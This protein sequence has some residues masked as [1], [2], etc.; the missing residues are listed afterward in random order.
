MLEERVAEL[1]DRLSAVEGEIKNTNSLLAEILDALRGGGLTPPAK[2]D[3]A[4]VETAPA[5]VEAIAKEA[6]NSNE[7]EPVAE[8]E[9]TSVQ[10][11]AEEAAAASYDLDDVR[12]AFLEARESVGKETAIG[13]IT[14]I[15]GAIKNISH[16]PKDKFAAVIAALKAQVTQEAA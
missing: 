8:A 1:A 6:D 7:P 5:K 4:E 3:E 13:A 11:F 2:P 12:A 9:P 15:T 14:D 10:D 16:V